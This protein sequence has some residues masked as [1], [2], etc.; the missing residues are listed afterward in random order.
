[1][2]VLF[3]GEYL[4][5]KVKSNNYHALLDIADIA[6]FSAY[7]QDTAVM[8]LSPTKNIAR[9]LFDLGLS[10]DH[11]AFIFVDYF[12]NSKRQFEKPKETD[13]VPEKINNKSKNKVK[14]ENNLKITNNAVAKTDIATINFDELKPLELREYQKIGVK[15]LLNTNLNQLL[16]DDMGVGKSVQIATYL[17]YKNSFPVLIICPASLKLNWNREIGIWTKKTCLILEGLTPYDI[18]EK[19][20]LSP[21]VIINYDILGRKDQA[22]VKEEKERVSKAKRMGYKF[23]HNRIYPTGWVDE[24]KKIPFSDVIC[25]ESQFIGEQNTARTLA[26]IDLMKNS[27]AKRIFLS[28]TPYTSAVSQFFT[29]LSLIQPNVFS[30]RWKFYQTYCSPVHTRFGWTFNGLS[31]G[32]ELHSRIK[33]FMLRRLKTDVLTELPDKIK[34]IIPVSLDNSYYAKYKQDE[35]FYLTKD[36]LKDMTNTY[37]LLKKAAY[38]AKYKA[39][40]QWIKEFLE[41]NDKLVVFIYHRESFQDLMNEFSKIAVGINGATPANSRIGIIDKFQRDSNIKLFIGQIKAAG[42]GIT[43]TAA[44]AVA[45]MEFGDTAAD[46][47]QAEDRIYRIGQESDKVVIYYL[48]ANDTIDESIVE[49]IGIKYTRQKLVM[50]GQENAEFLPNSG[51]SGSNLISKVIRDRAKKLKND[52]Y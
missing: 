11:S 24:L 49:N 16:A 22:A 27:K 43:L 48:I 25:D 45:F 17:R 9:K 42:V 29:T 36:D 31:N 30:N 50:D 6:S 51:D 46:H 4:N 39:C 3:D 33:T 41:V 52:I 37:Q 19:I 34:S 28:G 5:V 20:K 32:A 14:K 18:S 23:R 47:E 44:N 15:W 7:D 21:V 8:L 38:Y 26:V 40:I 35:R 13:K 10:F 12:E 2:D 1:M